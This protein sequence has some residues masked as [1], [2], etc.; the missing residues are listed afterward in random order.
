MRGK[1]EAVL[2]FVWKN[3]RLPKSVLDW[4]EKYKGI[5]RGLDEEAERGRQ[6]SG[7]FSPDFPLEKSPAA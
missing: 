7:L 4:R 6:G 3:D 5:S 1:S 2:T